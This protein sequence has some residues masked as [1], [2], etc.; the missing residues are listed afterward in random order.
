MRI[1]RKLI[2]HPRFFLLLGALIAA[3]VLSHVIPTLLPLAYMGLAVT[4]VAMVLDIL[5]LFRH[6]QG[7][8]ARRE[9]TQRLSNGDANRIEITL[10]NQYGFT[11]KVEIIDEVPVQF[12]WRDMNKK[13]RLAAGAE[14]KIHYYLR[15]VARGEYEFGDL[16]A[17]VRSP[18]GLF[19]RHWRF[20]IGQTVAVYPSFLQLQAYQ[21]LAMSNRL[22]ELGVKPIRRLGHSTEFEH[23]KEYVRGDDYRTINW[24]A[25]ARSSKLMV[26]QYMDERSQQIYCLIDKSRAMKMPFEGMALLDYAINASLVLAHIAISR[27]DRSGLLTFAKEIDQFLPASSRSGHLRNFQELLYRQETAFQESDYERVYVFVSRKL[28][29]RS[30]LVL[31]TNFESLSAMRRQL[32]YLKRMARQHL[33]LVVFFENTELT[34]LLT[35]AP[36]DTEGI[37]VKAIGEQLMYDKKLM[38]KE[39][40]QAGVPSMLT[41][42]ENLTVNTINK[43]LAIKA[44]S[45]I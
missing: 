40:A 19:I 24:K 45:Q 34:S 38:V 27:H 15:P 44:G 16:H 28:S 9:V 37:Y 7:V 42:P 25:T 2:L 3:F 8:L 43:Y 29:Q 26:N 17:L 30:L 22:T 18:I 31:F 1:M 14:A 10:T 6:R 33:L 23:I 41:A 13:L 20:A 21:L 4:V 5:L 39:L 11:L 32:P 36:A 12:Q 35:T